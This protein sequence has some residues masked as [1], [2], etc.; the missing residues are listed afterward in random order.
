VFSPDGRRIATV[1][2]EQ[3]TATSRGEALVWDAAT[4]QLLYRLQPPKL[5]PDVVFTLAFSP[6]GNLLATFEKTA[7]GPLQVVIRSAETRTPV[8]TIAGFEA[9]G[10][11]QWVT[12]SPDG[13]SVATGGLYQDAR[14]WDVQTGQARSLPL[15]HGNALSHV[16]FGPDNLHLL[17][18]GQDGTA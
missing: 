15:P 6:D 10:R 12:F 8:L 9:R 4:G 14:V 7:L 18:A 13:R 3:E 16:S 1:S 2:L 11:A 5:L 17:T